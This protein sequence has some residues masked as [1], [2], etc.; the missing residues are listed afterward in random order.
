MR[1]NRVAFASRLGFVGGFV[2][3][4]VALASLADLACTFDPK[5]PGRAT[6][7]ARPGDGGDDAPRAATPPDTA[8]PP[9]P[10]DMG[11]TTTPSGPAGPTSDDAGPSPTPPAPGTP[12]KLA[13]G[14]PCTAAADCDSGHCV[15]GVCCNGDC[16]GACKS[17]RL[18]NTGASDGTCA[19]VKPGATEP[20]GRCKVE[21]PPGCGQD[22]TCGDDG[23]CH[24]YGA[25]VSC[26]QPSCQGND[27]VDVGKCN[28]A[29]ACAA[30]A[31]VNCNPFVCS[32]TGCMSACTAVD[33]C[34][35][36]H[37]CAMGTCRVRGAPGQACDDV[38]QCRSG[39]FC[40]DGLCCDRACAGLC[41]ACRSTLTGQ[42]DGTCAPIRAG[43]DPANECVLQAASTCGTDGTCDGVGGCRLHGSDVQC[44]GAACGNNAHTPA[45]RC[46]GAGTC[47]AART[48]QCR[49]GEGCKV[50]SG[51]T[52][53]YPTCATTINCLEPHCSTNNMRYSADP[54]VVVDHKNG[55][56]LWQR[57]V[58]VR[59]SFAQAQAQCAAMN[60]A[61]V[62]GW[63]I[64]S[65]DEI[66]SIAFRAGGIAGKC[67][68]GPCC[69]PA[70]DQ[71]A[72]RFPMNP[73]A[74]NVWTEGT[75]IQPF[76][77]MDFSDGRI[78]PTGDTGMHS[79]LCVHAPL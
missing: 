44:A 58:L 75:P 67:A 34:A 72:F 47:A 6:S 77:V 24:R 42:P 60:R 65:G 28:G 22:G 48:T 68:D 70:V 7:A 25:S 52:P 11:T 2:G 19:V 10:T 71:S 3:G 4:L 5:L 55:A 69:S 53:E 76:R 14:E 40:V 17:C 73:D 61:G 18:A 50:A 36:G 9:A 74:W 21:P 30:A 54:E 63:R 56:R 64:P 20:N 32:P 78:K 33:S 46:T 37:Y 79:V 38:G 27:F 31:P 13:T 45:R 51:C 49:P 8:T 43:T 41:H 26:G 23:T 29:G 12:G 59:H 62:T 66:A 39:L 16:A 1:G 57:T 35:A 15:E